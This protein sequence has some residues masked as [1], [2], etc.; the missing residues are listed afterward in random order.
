MTSFLFLSVILAANPAPDQIKLLETFRAEFIEI[1]PE[2]ESE[3]FPQTFAMGST[4]KGEDTSRPVHEVS[5]NHRF[6]IA[7]YE[8][9]QNLWQA[10]V[11]ENRSKWKGPRNSAEMLSFDEA[12]QFCRQATLLMR[13]EKLISE[14]QIIRLPTEAEWEYVARA[15]TTTRY[16][17]G[18]DPAA[19]DAYAWHTGNAAGND[20]PVGAKKANPWGLYDIHGYLWE[21]C[22][23]DWHD[24]YHGAP[25]DG[26]VWDGNG[27]T[28][29]G[30]LRGGSWKDTADQLTSSYRR[31]APKELRDDAVGFRCV[32]AKTMSHDK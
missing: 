27:Q 13:A 23:D 6:Y 24:S 3:Q 20:P 9:P 26:K 32:L 12:V 16:S 2:V 15:G 21:W 11:G 28:T 7:K 19:S 18:N 4:T 14:D 1:H 10:V 29:H 5:L 25:R 30:V 17:F 31:R 8:I 22:A